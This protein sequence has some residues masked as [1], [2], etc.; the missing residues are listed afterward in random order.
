MLI[1]TVSRL[2]CRRRCHQTFENHGAAARCVPERIRE[3]V[4]EHRSQP[5]RVGRDLRKDRVDAAGQGDALG[6]RL[7][8][9]AAQSLRDHGGHLHGFQVEPE[10]ARLDACEI[11]EFVNRFGQLFDADQR[12]YRPARVARSGSRSDASFSI[13]S[14]I[15]RVVSGVCSS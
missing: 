2:S 3:D 8:L 1:D 6:I 13:N 14:V 7:S 9:H 4:V 5:E 10:L 15:R 11:E 12:R